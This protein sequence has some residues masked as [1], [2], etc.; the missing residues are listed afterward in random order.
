MFII[1]DLIMILVMVFVMVMVV[2][3]FCLHALHHFFFLCRTAEHIQQI[4]PDPV[5]IRR[6]L[7]GI[8][9]PFVRFAS[10]V[11]EQITG[12]NL[13]HIFHCR[14]I[15]VKVHTVIQKQRNLRTG[16]IFTQ[17]VH[18][19]VIFRENRRNDL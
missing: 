13:H 9:C 10:N 3:L 5:F 11:N 2:M 6:N 19:P 18:D 4:N 12:G 1:F 8:F 7:Q 14:L 16:G 15:A 17:N